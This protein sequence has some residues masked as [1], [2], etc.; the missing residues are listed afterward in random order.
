MTNIFS[1]IFFGAFIGI[2]APIFLFYNTDCGITT[3]LPY[4]AAKILESRLFSCVTT[5]FGESGKAAL[6]LVPGAG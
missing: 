4:K 1:S 6:D 3:S 5:R 2:T